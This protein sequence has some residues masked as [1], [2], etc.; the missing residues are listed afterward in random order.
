MSLKLQ[1]E[2]QKAIIDNSDKIK[3]SREPIDFIG[4]L[5]SDHKDRLAITKD[6]IKGQD[7]TYIL[8]AHNEN[9]LINIYIRD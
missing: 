1:L 6:K 2:I 3:I 9:G 8:S 5:L 4:E 7:L